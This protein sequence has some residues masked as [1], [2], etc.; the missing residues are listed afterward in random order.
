MEDMD[1]TLFI[2]KVKDFMSLDLADYK[3]TQMKRRLTSLRMKRGYDTF[4]AY[5]KA[6]T[7]NPVLLN[8]FKDRV[9]INV[10]EFWRNPNRWAVLEERFIPEILQKTPRPKC[11]S[12][13][14]ST[15]EEP[16]TLAMILAE[17]GVNHPEIIATDL[18]E[19]VLSK[20][21]IG[22]YLERSIRDVP[23]PYLDK[24]FTVSGQQY[25]IADKLKAMVKFR[26]GNLLLDEFDKHYD[27]IICRNVM[28]YFTEQAKHDLYMRFA[29]SLKPGGLLFVGST[30]QIFT[31]A[32]YG[33]ETADSFIYRRMSV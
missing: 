2:R 9:T 31:P 7:E 5:F 28:I 21:Q 12:A 33:L 20:A 15:G 24:Y 19:N 30:E 32:Q 1:Y 4:A 16:Y 23:K 22:L 11:W 6:I 26:K 27:L 13:A 14:C 29:A 8:E 10:S 18:D 17:K 3:E 25:Q